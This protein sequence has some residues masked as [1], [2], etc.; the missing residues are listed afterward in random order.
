MTQPWS[1][2][3][4]GEGFEQQTLTLDGGAVATLVRYLG[5][6]PEWPEAVDGIPDPAGIDADVLYVHGW[7][8]YFFQ[9]HVA[10]FWHRAG[11]RFYALDLHNYGRS[12]GPGLVPGFVTNL[13]DYD[14]DIA[15]ALSAMGRSGDAGQDRPLI[16]LGH[17][18]GGLTLSLWASRHPGIASALILN[19]P[20]LEFQATE[21]GRRAIAPLVGLH[22][23]LHPLAPLPPVDPGIYT[24]AVSATLD[25][26]W[27]YNLEWRPDRGFPITPAFLDAVF[28][29]Q[30]TVAAG[31]GIDVPVL[32]L[33]SD[34]S[35]LQPKWS[36]DALTADV[37]LNVDAV[38]H[39][40]LSL[41]DTVT[42]S[43]LP[44]AFHDIF[45][46]PEPVRRLA[47]ERIGRW[48]P[49]ALQP[50]NA[51]VWEARTAGL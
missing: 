41:A 25:G 8:D 49:M 11:A 24:R 50:S 29:G 34:K 13:A 2:D 3:I 15:A 20:W 32:V 47:F 1:P 17:S 4:L 35:Y 14:A 38:A 45:L 43:R 27:D 6:A 31:L 40:S 7:S 10:E 42:V 30:A 48:L 9:R 37:A 18:T 51:E 23:R 44:N 33:L 22:A 46:S 21:L 16:L 39:R 36:A 19:S 26:E 28:R 5:T 12:L